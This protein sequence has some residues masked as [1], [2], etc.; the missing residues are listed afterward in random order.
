MNRLLHSIIGPLKGGL[1]RCRLRK[2]CINCISTGSRLLL[3]WNK[4]TN[5]LGGSGVCRSSTRSPSYSLTR[6]AERATSKCMVEC[7]IEVMV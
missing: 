7:E 1:A 5:D 6:W 4:P 3:N 2:R